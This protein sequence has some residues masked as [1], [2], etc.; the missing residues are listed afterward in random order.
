MAMSR[1]QQARQK[2]RNQGQYAKVNPCYLCN[3]S[4][5]LDYTSHPLTDCDGSDGIHF[6]DI[7]LCICHRC[8]EATAGMT[9]TAQIDAYADQLANK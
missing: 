5:G 8:Y 4:A 7:A 1:R 9:T 2:H 3:K 6:G